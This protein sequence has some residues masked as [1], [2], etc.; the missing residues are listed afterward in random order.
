MLMKDLQEL[1]ESYTLVEL[2]E[3]IDGFEVRDD[4]FEA[5]VDSLF[6]SSDN[7]LAAIMSGSAVPSTAYLFEY[8][9]HTNPEKIQQDLLL[10]QYV[11]LES[12]R[13]VYKEE[14]CLFGCT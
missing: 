13:R 6:K 3:F 4:F 11:I 9:A 1:A 12:V 7:P 5:V 14:S 2:N 10:F 8:I